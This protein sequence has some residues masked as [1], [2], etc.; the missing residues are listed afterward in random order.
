[1]PPES[2]HFGN[3][4]KMGDCYVNVEKLNKSFGSLPQYV[5]SLDYNNTTE[6]SQVESTSV[7]KQSDTMNTNKASGLGNLSLVALNL[8]PDALRGHLRDTFSGCPKA[9]KVP[10]V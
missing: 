1:M 7:W 4:T 9:W 3:N 2:R 10:E 5:C 8:L 6:P